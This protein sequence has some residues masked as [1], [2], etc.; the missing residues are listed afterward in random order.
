MF[1]VLETLTIQIQCNKDDIQCLFIFEVEMFSLSYFLIEEIVSLF[2]DWAPRDC[3]VVG[4]E[5]LAHVIGV[6]LLACFGIRNGSF[7]VWGFFFYS[8]HK[9]MNGVKEVKTIREL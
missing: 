6:Q 2:I 9:L 1:S 5:Q 7:W 4:M 8:C 3:S